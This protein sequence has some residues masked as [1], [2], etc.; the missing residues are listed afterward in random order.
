MCVCVCVF[1]KL[2]ITAQSGLFTPSHSTPLA[3]VL[4]KGDQSYL[5]SK[6]VR[7]SFL[8]LIVLTVCLVLIILIISSS[9]CPERH[10]NNNLGETQILSF[11]SVN[12]DVC[13]VIPF[14]TSE[15]SY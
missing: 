3:V 7:Y 5:F 2:H 4:P 6:T 15:A 14:I 10:N 11:E 1:I 13:V 8:V 12:P 9:P